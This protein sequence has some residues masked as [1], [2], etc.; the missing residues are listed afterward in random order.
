M[1]KVKEGMSQGFQWIKDKCQHGGGKKQQGSEAPRLWVWPV[2]RYWW[3]CSCRGPRI[4]ERN[5]SHVMPVDT[6]LGLVEFES[7]CLI[8]ICSLDVDVCF[9]VRFLNIC[10]ENHDMH[11]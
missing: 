11:V 1:R 2:I 6:S 8:K 10:I 9:Y 4:R 3:C 7:N 5:S